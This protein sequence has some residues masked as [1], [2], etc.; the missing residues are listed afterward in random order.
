MLR[1]VSAVASF[2]AV[3]AI[4]MSETPLYTVGV[5]RSR[6]RPHITMPVSFDALRYSS[7]KATN[8]SIRDARRAGK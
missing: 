6:Q 5:A 4:N 7:R 3:F 8:G 2:L 1:L